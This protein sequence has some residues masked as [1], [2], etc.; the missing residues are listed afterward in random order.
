VILG[1]A[2]VICEG[3]GF[4]L[5]F[6]A[7]WEALTTAVTAVAIGEIGDKTQLL[8]LVLAARFPKQAWA[9]I[10]GIVVATLANHAAAVALGAWSAHWLTPEILRWV[11]GLSFVAL[12]AWA[13]FPDKLDDGEVKLARNAFIATTVAFFIAEIGDKTQVATV[14]IAARYPAFPVEVVI[15]TTLGMV[16][17]NA[18]VIWAGEKLLA[19]VSM[20]LVRMVAALIFVALGLAVMVFGLPQF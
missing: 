2:F 5:E 13:L 7:M 4:G 6:H 8:T 14:L 1:R 11:L 20:K 16:L 9:I 15:G 10:S 17:A 19:R 18:P 3:S 12:A